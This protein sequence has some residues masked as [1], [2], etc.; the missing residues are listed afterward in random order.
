[1]AGVTQMFGGAQSSMATL[2]G[3]SALL[4]LPPVQS[5]T[6]AIRSAP[7]RGIELRA[8]DVAQLLGN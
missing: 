2:S 7:Q 5:V 3:L 6:R 1:L 8:P 4:S